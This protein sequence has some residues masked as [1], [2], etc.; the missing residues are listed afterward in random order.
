MKKS[1]VYF[2]FVFALT[3]LASVT[4]FAQQKAA[5]TPEEADAK[6]TSLTSDISSLKTKS[7]NLDGDIKALKADIEK[8]S[9]EANDCEDALY[10]LVDAKKEQIAA[11]REKLD[12]T[13]KKID[14]LSKLSS[15]DLF[16][17]KSEIDN[18]EATAKELRNSKISLLPEFY[19]RVEALQGKIQNL[20]D[21]LKKA[22]KTYVV[23][24]WSR[25]KDCLWNISKKADIYDNP[26]MWPKIWQGNRD[27]IKDPDVIRTGWELKIPTPAPLTDEETKNAR[28]YWA[29]KKE[30][31]SG[32]EQ[33]EKIREQRVE[34]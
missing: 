5:M 3:Y 11:F 27:K 15:M 34:R 13:E 22:E 29:K 14:E 33:K 24:T 6:I 23:G 16:S 25:D 7:S 4:L 20:R 21:A 9:V 28:A 2:I 19:D 32:V 31:E 30:A 26:F 17:R 10:A 1:V 8:K 12:N 18:V